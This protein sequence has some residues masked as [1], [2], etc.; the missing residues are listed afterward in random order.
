MDRHGHGSWSSLPAKAGE[1]LRFRGKGRRRGSAQRWLDYPRP[2]LK[3]GTFS[4]PEVDTVAKLHSVSILI[5]FKFA[6]IISVDLE[7]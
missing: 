5:T 1:S 7:L 4:P 2:G 3:H 6:R